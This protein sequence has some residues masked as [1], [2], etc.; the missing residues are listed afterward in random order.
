MCISG[1][2]ASDAFSSPNPQC[3]AGVIGSFEACTIVVCTFVPG[4]STFS[5]ANDTLAPALHYLVAA[6]FA[7]EVKI[8][9]PVWSSSLP[10]RRMRGCFSGPTAQIT[11]FPRHTRHPATAGNQTFVNYLRALE[12]FLYKFSF[13]KKSWA[14]K[15][16]ARKKVGLKRLLW[17]VSEVWG[18]QHFVSWH[19]N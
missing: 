3:F 12:K 8:A 5:W 14:R 4:S 7:L 16:W 17:G 15:I 18:E 11:H 13:P 1:T 6:T 10:R 9:R 2:Y 19:F